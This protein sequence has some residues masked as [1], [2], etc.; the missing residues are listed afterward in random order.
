MLGSTR[1]IG[2]LLTE[3]GSCKFGKGSPEFGQVKLKITYKH[4][5]EDIK[6]SALLFEFEIKG[7]S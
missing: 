7:G 2:L 4:L 6:K 1:K 3:K 5:R